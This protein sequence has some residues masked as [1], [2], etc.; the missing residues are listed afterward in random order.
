MLAHAGRLD[1]SPVRST[2]LPND[3]DGELTRS[4]IQAVKRASGFAARHG[5]YAKA[6][7][8]YSVLEPRSGWR[9]DDVRQR[10][11]WLAY[12]AGRY[13]LAIK[14]FEELESPRHQP[15][16]LYWRARAQERAGRSEAAQKLFDE[17]LEQHLRTYYGQIGRSRLVEAGKVELASVPCE[18]KAPE[19]KNPAPLA[20][21]L[22]KRYGKLLPGLRR[23]AALARMGMLEQAR[24]EARLVGRDYTWAKYRGRHRAY[25]WRTRPERLWTGAPVASRRERPWGRRQ[26]QIRAAGERLSHGLA[27]LMRRLDLGYFA[28]RLGPE[29]RND[30][31]RT[32][33]RAYQQVVLDAAERF[34][35]DPNLL[36]AIIRTESAFRPDAISRVGAGG[37]MQLMPATAARLAK[38]LD[39]KDFK[40]V[41]AFDPATNVP[42]G[43]DYLSSL[44]KKFH[45]QLPLAAA[46]YNGGPHNVSRWLDY[47]GKVSDLDEFVEEIPFRE[48]RRYAKKIVRLV[49]LY[50]RAHCGKDDLVVAK[51]LDPTYEPYPNF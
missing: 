22:A 1:E 43:A 10:L 7:E 51:K 34:D 11:G 44:L 45:G 31:R 23:V 30:E 48:S 12:R 14:H 8:I 21:R 26:R 49:S 16:S 36:W 40:W 41:N 38:R 25:R 6:L 5:Q 3:D 47:R 39:M 50:E 33:P 4:E 35:I 27:R 13:D 46:A 24:R 29:D 17:L 28:W 18:I 9:G 15:F 2:S 19:R 37:L 20:N 42:L 32:H